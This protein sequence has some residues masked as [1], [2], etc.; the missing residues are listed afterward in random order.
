MRF[1]FCQKTET[2]VLW[3]IVDTNFC[4][5][6]CFASLIV[7][8]ARDL[9]ILKNS[10]FS[11]FGNFLNLFKALFLL[12]I[13]FLHSSFHQGTCLFGTISGDLGID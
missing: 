8:L 3:F 13:T 11:S 6:V 5:E 1:I 7:F 9:A 12:R 10:K 2:G 4:H